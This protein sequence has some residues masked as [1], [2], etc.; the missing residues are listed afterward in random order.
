MKSFLILAILLSLVPIG[1]K[2]VPETLPE[3]CFPKVT[4]NMETNLLLVSWTLPPNSG[5]VKGC[6]IYAGFLDGKKIGE[7][8]TDKTSFEYNLERSWIGLPLDLTI[9]T[10][11]LE[12]SKGVTVSVT[13]TAARVKIEGID[14][15]KILKSGQNCVIGFTGNRY[16]K[17]RIRA[18]IVVKSESSVS[19]FSTLLEEDQKTL[20]YIPPDINGMLECRAF[21]GEKGSVCVGFAGCQVSSS[22]APPK[23][24]LISPSKGQTFFIGDKVKIE[25]ESSGM[26]VGGRYKCEIRNTFDGGLVAEM[27]VPAGTNSVE[28]LV[29]AQF[30]YKSV[31]VDVIFRHLTTLHATNPEFPVIIGIDKH[32][33]QIPSKPVV[34]LTPDPIRNAVQ[35]DITTLNDGSAIIDHVESTVVDSDGS[36]RTYMLQ[37][38]YSTTTNPVSLRHFIYHVK[39]GTT[40]SVTAFSVTGDATSIDSEKVSLTVPVDWKAV[41][42]TSL[43]PGDS[44]QIGSRLKLK[45]GL[46]NFSDYL[47]AD[48]L[49]IKTPLKEYSFDYVSSN[50]YETEME[51]LL[52]GLV[53]SDD[54]KLWIRAVSVPDQKGQYQVYFECVDN[55]KIVAPPPF[56][57]KSAIDVNYKATLT[58][59]PVAGAAYYNIRKK[60]YFE[61]FMR[62]KTLRDQTSFEDD[63]LSPD[64]RYD[65]QIEARGNRDEVIARAEFSFMT[66]HKKIEPRLNKGRTFVSIGWDRIR[67]IEGYNIFRQHGYDMDLLNN[68]TLT[69]PEYI[70]SN[71]TPGVKYCYIIQGVMDDGRIIG[72]SE[73]ACAT[74]DLD[75]MEVKAEPDTQSV[76]LSWSP[77]PSIFQYQVFRKNG[78]SF[79]LVGKEI[80]GGNYTDK[81]LEPLKDYTYMVEGL[82]YSGTVMARSE[83]VTATTLQ[84]EHATIAAKSFPDQIKLFWPKIT[85]VSRLEMWKDGT[86]LKLLMPDQTEFLDFGLKPETKYCYALKAYNKYA[87]LVSTGDIC[88]QTLKKQTVVQFTA[89]S[90][91]WYINGI[92][93]ADMVSPPEITGGRLYLVVRYLTQSVEAGLSWDAKTK[94]V[95]IMRKDG[96]WIK[97]Q[98]GNPV[99]VVNGRETPIDPNNKSVSPYVKNGLTYC[100]FRFIANNLGASDDNITWD[101]GRKT[102]KIVF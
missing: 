66:Q 23:F 8:P 80:K 44:I 49:L 6:R 57:V 77:Q 15:G 74:T 46:V 10:F 89:G 50:A 22:N 21:L 59:E 94:T 93:Q 56:A 68:D 53:E 76:R 2:A 34:K 42:I 64:S 100:P 61:K 96:F 79:E 19:T 17:D 28:W 72:S 13:P 87:N 62:I 25:W 7:L 11:G 78:D 60:G 58:W 41:Y 83:E 38:D 29:P 39:A 48:S 5:D 54:V 20:I 63:Q 12:E 99:A 32:E 1:T 43:K 82:D 47:G 67:W 88:A 9:K 36:T 84:I 70:D 81:G 14:G 52:D 27:D 45:W 85:N 73:L 26:P 98:V 91:K 16:V 97:M 24:K 75:S 18:E 35:V 4:W 3:V 55:L 92:E 37:P 71:L 30:P 40:Y 69:L 65:Y 51:V 31:A 102:V 101:A 90:K 33:I 86:L 95:E